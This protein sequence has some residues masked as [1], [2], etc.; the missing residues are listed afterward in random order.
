MVNMVHRINLKCR[1]TVYKQLTCK[2][3]EKCGKHFQSNT[4]YIDKN[5]GKMI[6]F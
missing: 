5:S 3:N 2:K 1:S 4:M 6:S